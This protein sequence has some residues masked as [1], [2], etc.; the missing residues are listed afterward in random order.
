MS[1]ERK[2]DKMEYGPDSSDVPLASMFSM[3]LVFTL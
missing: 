2:M 1:S 3:E